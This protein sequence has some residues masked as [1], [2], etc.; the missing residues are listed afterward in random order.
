[1][2]DVTVRDNDDMA[3]ACQQTVYMD[4]SMAY[5]L[6]HETV[7]ICNDRRYMTVDLTHEID[8]T[9]KNTTTIKP[10]VILPNHGRIRSPAHITHVEIANLTT[11]V[12]AKE[13]VDK[14]MKV[15]VL[16]FANPIEPGGG[17]LSGSRAQEESLCR[18]SALYHT[19]RDNEM[20]PWHSGRSDSRLASDWCIWS[21]DVPVFRNDIGDFLEQPWMMSVL[22]CAAP[23]AN[24]ASREEIKAIMTKRISRVLEVFR[25]NEASHLVLGAWGCGAFGCDPNDIAQ[26]FAEALNNQY[27]GVFDFI[28]FAIADW[29][30]GRRNLGPFVSAF[31]NV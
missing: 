12:A 23:Q 18:S 17:F 10:E 21:P 28:S 8:E 22:T 27:D 19:I 26:I 6:G 25:N 11:L 1:M 5:R 15:A 3:A 13:I 2:I 4:R 16:N 14:G 9:V 30:P 20:Y 24:F 31:G 7:Q 29:S